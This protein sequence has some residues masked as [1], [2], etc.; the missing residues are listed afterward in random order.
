MYK[1]TADIAKEAIKKIPINYLI[2]SHPYGMNQMPGVNEREMKQVPGGNEI[3]MKYVPVG[4][5]TMVPLQE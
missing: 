4:N 5:E 3:E 2:I 1:D